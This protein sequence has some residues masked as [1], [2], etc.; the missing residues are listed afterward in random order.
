MG[1]RREPAPENG[2][3]GAAAKRGLFSVSMKNG[4]GAASA[5]FQVGE[6]IEIEF[7]YK[8]EKE[9]REPL[10]GINIFRSDGVLVLSTNQE[11]ASCAGNKFSQTVNGRRPGR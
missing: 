5:V 2:R 7:E 8:T 6:N 11:C 9:V 4:R 1:Q 10:F 3:G